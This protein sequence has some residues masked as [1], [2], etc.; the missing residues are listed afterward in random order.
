M[1]RSMRILGDLEVASSVVLV[2]GAAVVLLSGGEWWIGMA[3][4]AGAGL[5][6]GAGVRHR[7]ASNRFGGSA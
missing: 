2:T 1:W 3:G 7:S 4:L 5:L 6:L